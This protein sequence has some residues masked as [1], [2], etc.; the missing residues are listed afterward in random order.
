MKETL[1]KYCKEQFAISLLNSRFHI[2]S[3]LTEGVICLSVSSSLKCSVPYG[4]L[5]KH[6]KSVNL[7]FCAFTNEQ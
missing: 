5:K 6:N 2:I 4:R 3:H 1:S 7:V